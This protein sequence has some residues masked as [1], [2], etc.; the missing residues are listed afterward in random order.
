V[1]LFIQK[2]LCFGA[3]ITGTLFIVIALLALVTDREHDYTLAS[4]I[5]D[6]YMGDSRIELAINDSML[7][8]SLNLG[9]SSESFYYSYYKL[10]RILK[11]TPTIRRVFLGIGHHSISS[12][13]DRFVDG[14]FS[15]AVAPRYFNLLPSEQ[16]ARILKA[17]TGD[18]LKFMR[19]YILEGLTKL[20]TDNENLQTSAFA[21][22]FV[23][24][25]AVE[26][27]MDK[28][29]QFQYYTNRRL[30]NFSD[31]NMAYLQKI[32][33]LCNER[34]VEII[35]LGCP[36]HAY[37]R[38]QIPKPYLE[39]L[40]EVIRCEQVRYIDLS[41]IVLNDAGYAPDGDHVSREGARETT[42]QLFDSL[43]R[44]VHSK[45]EHGATH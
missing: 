34:N 28:R 10:D 35:L 27:S 9:A 13:Y 33:R 21:N 3:A 45:C 20:S 19:N 44:R 25:H 18:F 1:K 4:S 41:A 24:T 15:V 22:P 11:N 39:K 38:Q 37:Y 17:N 40:C 6:I 43:E 23:N 12:Y 30:N 42:L 31:E 16:Q 5:R 32:I 7:P 36:Q 26:A 8:N 14:H 2:I 29:A